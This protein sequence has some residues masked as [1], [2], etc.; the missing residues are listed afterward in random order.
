VFAVEFMKK[1]KPSE[2]SIKEFEHW[3]VLLREKQV[4]L[5]ASIIA[6]KREVPSIAQ[7][8]EEEAAEFP[9]VIAWFEKLNTDLF[10]AEKFNYIAAMMKDPFV[11]YH[12]FPRYS[13]TVAKF[14]V[15]WKDSC[16]PKVIEFLEVQFDDSVLDEVKNVMRGF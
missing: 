6:L 11:H 15:E 14:G 5:G 10:G 4:T 3:V 8:T 16:W 13:A 1:F 7:M 2:N 12:A 9:K